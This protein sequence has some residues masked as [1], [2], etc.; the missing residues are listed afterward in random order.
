VACGLALG[1]GELLAMAAWV[2]AT[3]RIVDVPPP[4]AA[5]QADTASTA[6]NPVI[7]PAALM[8]SRMRI[9]LAWYSRARRCDPPRPGVKLLSV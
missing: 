3:S 5:E 2:P 6:A 8:V 9:N 7:A 1:L 4:P